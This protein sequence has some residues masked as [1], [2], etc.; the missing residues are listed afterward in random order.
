MRWWALFTCVVVGHSLAWGEETRQVELAF[1]Q[2]DAAVAQECQPDTLPQH[3]LPAEEHACLLSVR[4]LIQQRAL[5]TARERIAA[6]TQHRDSPEWTAALRNLVGDTYYREGNWAA[7]Q[8]AYQTAADAAQGQ[9]LYPLALYN[10]A[11]ATQYHGDLTKTREVLLEVMR[12]A[13]WSFEAESARDILNEDAYLTVQVGAFHDRAN[14]T[15]LLKALQQ[16]GYE[17]HLQEAVTRGQLHVRVRVGRFT[18]YQE[19]A[20]MRDEL[21]RLGYPARIHP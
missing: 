14:A 3:L 15:A 11:R 4:A 13:P 1:L 10:V 6:L 20:V 5:Q 8:Q 18:S 21:D 7:A 19:A 2:G 16:R 9:E 17:A 12:L